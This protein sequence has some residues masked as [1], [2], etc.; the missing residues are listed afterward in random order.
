MGETELCVPYGLQ[1]FKGKMFE[2]W[3]QRQEAETD[4]PDYRGVYKGNGLRTE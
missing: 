2:V 1:R 3:K 4:L